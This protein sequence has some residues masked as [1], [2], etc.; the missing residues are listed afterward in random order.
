MLVL[1]WVP[2]SQINWC[3]IWVTSWTLEEQMANAAMRGFAQIHFEYLLLFPGLGGPAPLTS[4]LVISH[5]DYCNT[6][7]IGL[8]LKTT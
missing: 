2:L 6:L 1:D 5:V 7:Y 4:A 3:T 8:Q